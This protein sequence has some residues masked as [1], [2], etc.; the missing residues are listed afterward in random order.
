MV[1]ILETSTGRAGQDSAGM[2]EF[3]AAEITEALRIQRAAFLRD[4]PPS[5]ALRR[6]R[7]DRISA[8]SFENADAIADAMNADFGTRSS[9]TTNCIEVLAPISDFAHIRRNLGRWMSRGR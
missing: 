9:Q 7:M 4:G 2:R 6:N 8:L 5:L 1:E 3:S